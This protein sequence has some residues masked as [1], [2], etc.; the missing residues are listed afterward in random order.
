[1]TAL[2]VIGASLG[3]VD[4]VTSL[5]AS[6]PE[7]FPGAIVVVQHRGADENS[8]LVDVLGKRTRLRVVE[9]EDRQT[10]VPGTVYLAPSDYHVLVDEDALCLSLDAPV[11]FSRPSIDVLFESAAESS[12]R[13]LVGVLLSA[14]SLDGASGLEA[15]SEAGGRTLVQDPWEARSAVAISAALSR[16]RPDEI[17]K[18]NDLP[19]A[20]LRAVGA[21]DSNDSS[22]GK[23]GAGP[24][25]RKMRA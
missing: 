6:L 12:V 1:M 19:L 4:L 7:D 5:L 13:P 24:S 2:V 17:V 10:L 21:A 11:H 22:R 15:I 16:F 3:G 14:S 9:P 25:I 8:R 18:T 20:L 23:R